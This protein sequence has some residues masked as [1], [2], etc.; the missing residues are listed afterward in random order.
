MSTFI[1]RAVSTYSNS[2]SLA[3][4]ALLGAVLCGCSETP[5]KSIGKDQY[6]VLAPV[7]SG[8]P[9]GAKAKATDQAVRFCAAQAKYVLFGHDTSAECTTKGGCAEVAVDFE[10]VYADDPR[11]A[12]Q[13]L[14]KDHDTPN[15]ETH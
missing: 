15:T 10:C 8:G 7:H 9:A 1:M 2:R 5:P 14:G 3:L 12:R 13:V 6:S 4:A 11:Y